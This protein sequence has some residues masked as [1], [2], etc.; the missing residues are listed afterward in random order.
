MNIISNSD[1]SSHLM[2]IELHSLNIENGMYIY[3]YLQDRYITFKL[4][5]LIPN[6]VYNFRIDLMEVLQ[7]NNLQCYEPQVNKRYVYS[8]YTSIP[9]KEIATDDNTFTLH[10]DYDGKA[11]FLYKIKSQSNGFT[12]GMNIHDKLGKNDAILMM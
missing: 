6:T 8:L 1:L 7:N 2:N 12:T 3:R 5:N 10:S 4:T 11:S 9:T